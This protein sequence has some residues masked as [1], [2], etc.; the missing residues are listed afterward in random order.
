M[1]VQI[2]PVC[3]GNLVGCPVCN[4]PPKR[5]LPKESGMRGIYNRLHASLLVTPV[6]EVQGVDI[7]SWNGDMNLT[8]TKTKCQY[9]IIRAGY[10]SQW[11]D[12][13]L[14]I[15]YQD[16]LANNLPMGLYWYL[17]TNQDPII[18]AQGFATVIA[19]HPP[20]L[21]IV[22]DV[23]STTLN[24]VDTLNWLIAVDKKLTALTGKKAMI[25][26]SPG[27]WNDKVARSTYWNGRILWVATW[28][29]ADYPTM[30]LDFTSWTH[31]QGSADGNGKAKEYG[32][33]GNGDAD[34]D[35]NRFYST[36]DVFNARYGTHIRPIGEVPPPPGEVPE[37]VI[38]TGTTVNLRHVPDASSPN[39]VCGYTT[40]GKVL[41]PEAIEKDPSG[42]NWYR[43][44]KKIYIKKDL[45]RLP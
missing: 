38:V 11:E 16:A 22:L 8:I 17:Y 20:Q 33:T 12:S 15:Y 32:C 40:A 21:D 36:V 42:E 43:L 37:K 18:T 31:W 26:T 25:Y 2:C 7:S 9:I 34:M 27:F 6:W 41:Y 19:A 30:P 1:P 13:K 35:L 14:N 44:G 29:T 39:T 23:E 45:T 4:A 24:K 5:T 3:G 28:T 10:G